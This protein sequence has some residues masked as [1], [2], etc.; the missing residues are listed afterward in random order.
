MTSK[1]PAALGTEFAAVYADDQAVASLTPGRIRLVNQDLIDTL[2]ATGGAYLLTGAAGNGTTDD[3]SAFQAALSALP[4]GGV[5]WVPMPASAYLIS[6]TLTLANVSMW[7]MGGIVP[8]TFHPS[9]STVDCINI[10][11]P[12]GSSQTTVLLQGF[13]LNATASRFGRDLV[14]VG[15]GVA[16]QLRDLVLSNAGRDGVHVEANAQFSYTELLKCDNVYS[17]V[18]GRDNFHFESG[19]TGNTDY[20]NQT[21]MVNC[22]SR[23]PI[24]YALVL[25]NNDATGTALS[26]ISEM[27]WYCG[28]LDFSGGNQADGCLVQI[29]NNVAATIEDIAFYETAIEDVNSA[30]TGYGITTSNT[31]NG[32]IGPISFSPTVIAFGA[33]AGRLNSAGLTKFQ[34][35]YNA[36][37]AAASGVITNNSGTTYLMAGLAFQ[38]KQYTNPNSGRFLVS[39]SGI[40]TNNT[41]GDGVAVVLKWGTGTAPIAGAA[42]TGTT[43]GHA[44]GWID[45][46]PNPGKYVPFA[47]TD[48]LTGVQGNGTIWLDVA[49]AANTGGTASISGIVLTA[50]ELPYPT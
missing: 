23:A 6:G 15:G 25:L 14:R 16:I 29:A 43:V 11:A 48:I 27:S 32:S 37:S 36:A 35:P 21:V 38:V 28:E 26:K 9:S 42:L 5:L 40:F 10:S 45:Q 17:H 39:C 3:T 33:S 41:A 8:I 46:I 50:Q 34:N 20:I 31:A 19:N 2:S 12:T 1:T 47:F 44:V 49:F 30:H 18:A 13:S 22:V 7:G 24:R 4:A